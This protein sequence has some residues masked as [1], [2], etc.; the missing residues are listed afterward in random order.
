ML[1]GALKTLQIGKPHVFLEVHDDEEAKA[2]RFLKKLNYKIISLP[3]AMYVATQTNR[4]S[5]KNSDYENS[6][7]DPAYTTS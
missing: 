1:K 3:G 7:Y 5:D 2:I 4:L 6:L